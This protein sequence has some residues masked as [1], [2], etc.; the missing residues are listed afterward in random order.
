MQVPNDLWFSLAQVFVG[1]FF[2]GAA[3]YKANSF[4][5]EHDRTLL[6]HVEYWISLGLPPKWY[7]EF[8]LWFLHLPYGQSILEITIILSQGVAGFLLMIRHK[9][10]VAGLL[11]LFVQINIFLCTFSNTGFNQFVGLSVWIALLYVFSYGKDGIGEK[12]WTLLTMILFLLQ[13]LYL[14]NRL[15]AGDPWISS[16]PVQAMHVQTEI[17]SFSPLWKMFVVW[18]ASFTIGKVLWASVWWLQ[19]VGALLM[20]TK[21]TRLVGGALVLLLLMIQTLTWTNSITS[22]GVIAVLTFYLWTTRE[23]AFQRQKK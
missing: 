20:L 23:E 22:H 2:V 21:R 3:M 5:I 12:R 14:W 15:I 6:G 4:F 16:V 13:M 1:L 9:T 10:F 7:G 18:M 17:M 11:L 8:L 19:L